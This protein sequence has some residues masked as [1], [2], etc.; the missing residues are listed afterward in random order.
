MRFLQMPHIEVVDKNKPN[1]NIKYLS[2]L[3]KSLRKLASFA[4]NE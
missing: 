1:E 3:I 4:K 2:K